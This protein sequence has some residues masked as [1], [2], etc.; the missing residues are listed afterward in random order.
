MNDKKKWSREDDVD[1]YIKDILGNLGL[2]KNKDYNCKSVMSDYMKESLKGASKTDKKSN[3]GVPDFNIEIYKIPVIIENKIELN[4]LCL[5]NNNE[6]IFDDKAISSY[7][8]NGVLWYARN[9]VKK[10]SEVIAIGI[11][12]DSESNVKIKVYH[13]TKNNMQLISNIENLNFLESKNTF[14]LFYNNILL[15]EEQKHEAIIKSKKEIVEHAKKLNKL[16][17]THNITA[18]QRILYISG[19][20]L[21]MQDI[22]DEDGNLEKAGLTPDELK[23]LQTQKG[24]DSFLIINQIEDFLRSKRISEDKINLM[25]SS[26]KEISKSSIRDEITNNEKEVSTLIKEKSSINKQI[27]V[28]IY[29]YIFHKINEFNSSLD[30]MGEMYSEFLQY[31]LGDGKDLGIVLTPPYITSLMCKL[32]DINEDDRVMD[33]AT[34][35]SGFL[36]AAMN[37]MIDLSVNKYGAGTTATKRK[38][39][40]IKSKGLLGIEL[41]S[42][43]FTLASTNMILRGDGSSNILQKNTFET[44]D[45]IFDNF[46]PNKILLNPP[47]SYEEN[48]MPF[49]EYGLRRIKS[50]LGA[51]IIQDSAGSGKAIKTNKEI[52]KHNTL[53]ASIKMPPDLFTPMATVQTSIYIFEANKPHDFE[54]PV[55]FI[56]F[57]NDGYKRTKRKLQ[58]VSNPTQRYNDIIK[59][60]KSGK[61]TKTDMWNLDEI[62]IEDL[63]SDSGKDWNFEQHIKLGNSV[64]RDKFKRGVGKYLLFEI[65]RLLSEKEDEI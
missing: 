6:I 38:I 42:E 13:V 41:N 27:F 59:I 22:V 3:F 45:E 5:K 20:L 44:E 47:F 43:L 19:M 2:V 34:G 61:L 18:Q 14:D 21:S 33:L 65:S 24:K 35:T 11:A 50:G 56:D 15:T 36:V 31:A 60:F 16:M 53:L 58:E 39:K 52:L 1:D 26:F 9:M 62:Y 55:K 57:K 8:V 63:I 54:K 29:K 32:I 12:G 64:T 4:K 17:H 23:G 51:I 37:Q 48:G 49:I 40:E 10:Y 46:C 7:A 25:L 30:V 28:Y